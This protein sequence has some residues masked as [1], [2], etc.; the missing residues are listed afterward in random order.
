MTI[1]TAQTT[2]STSAVEIAGPDVMAQFVTVHNNSSNQ[3]VYVGGSNVT[4]SNGFH[5]DGKEEH[6]FTLHPGD[7]LYAVSSGSDT[8][9]II[10]QKQ[11]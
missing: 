5:I 10:I 1:V 8:V 2:V 11:R 7:A 6:M 3:Q 4:T 9:S